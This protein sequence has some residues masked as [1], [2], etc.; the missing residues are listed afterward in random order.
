M[1]KKPKTEAGSDALVHGVDLREVERV[2][3]FMRKHN[4]EEFE[5]ERGD[6]HIRLKKAVVRPKGEMAA[7]SVS[8]AAAAYAPGDSLPARAPEPSV[9]V[10]KAPED[11]HLIKSPIVGTYYASPS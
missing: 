7:S 9:A 11:L 2:L 8:P 4:L 3:D 1:P 6:V 5:Y 10:D